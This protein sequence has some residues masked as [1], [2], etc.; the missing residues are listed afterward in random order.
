[1]N[2]LAPDEKSALVMAYTHDMLVRG[3]LVVKENMRV[4][5]WLRTQGVPDFIHIIKP[6]I[7]LFGGSAPKT[8]KYSEFFIP[9]VKLMAFHLAP[10][11]EEPLD[12]EKDEMNRVM[13][14]IDVLLGTFLIKGKIRI[15]SQ[16]DIATSLDVSRSTWMSIYDASITNPSLPQFDLQVP[17]LLVNSSEVNFGLV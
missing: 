10:P 17:M 3:E 13:K 2:P 6:Q 9:T 4:N 1:M 15:S 16:I 7:V 12:Y 8:V 14:P 11:S 5:I